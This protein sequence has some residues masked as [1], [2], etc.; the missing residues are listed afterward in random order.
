MNVLIVASTSLWLSWNFEPLVVAALLAIAAGYLYAARAALGRRPGAPAIKRAQL[1]SFATG[2]T[3]L[4]L[5]LV[6]PLHALGMSYLLT[7]H[8]AQHMLL[9][10]VAP[11]LLLL[12][13]PAWMIEPLFRGRA[14]GWLASWLTYP[15]VAYGLYYA[16]IWLWHVPALFDAQP[17]AAVGI[18]LRLVDAAVVLGALLLIALVLLP[19][20]WRASPWPALRRVP[21]WL[22][23]AVGLCAVVLILALSSS[24]SLSAPAFQPHNP[25]HLL[26]AALFFGTAIV[27]WM[28]VLSP[29]GAPVRRLSLG[30]SML[31]L[32]VSTQPMMALGAL[33]TFA[34]QPLYTVYAGAPLILGFTRLGD[35]QLAGLIMWL[36]MDV[37]LLLGISIL[38]FRWMNHQ[39]LT[40]RAAAG[41]YDEIAEPEADLHGAPVGEVGEVGEAA[42]TMQTMQTMQ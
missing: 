38:F 28:P 29:I 35:Q 22:V 31:Y 6:S 27:Y 4:A 40:A 5:A 21:L 16:N 20:L 13:I 24:T 15:A 14:V 8:M 42:P 32:F 25:L 23:S 19:R 37:P 26:M 33:L 12:G 39:E 7:A 2:W 30:A 11:P 34:P 10:V 18:T 41:E 1:A 9:T 17:P 3:L 36:L